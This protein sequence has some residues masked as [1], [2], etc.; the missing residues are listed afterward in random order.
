M[1]AIPQA[2]LDRIQQRFAVIEAELAQGAGGETFVKLSK[3]YS[4]LSP[5]V[6]RSSTT[7]MRWPL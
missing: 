3:E 6:T 2:K 7:T 4:E 1:S 5:V